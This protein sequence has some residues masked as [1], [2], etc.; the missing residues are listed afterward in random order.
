LI[1]QFQKSSQHLKHSPFETRLDLVSKFVGIIHVHRM[2]VED[3]AVVGDI[4]TQCAGCQGD[5]IRQHSDLVVCFGSQRYCHDTRAHVL[6]RGDDVV[7]DAQIRQEKL[8]D[9]EC[10]EADNPPAAPGIVPRAER[11]LGEE[12]DDESQEEPKQQV[13]LPEIPGC[14]CPD[15]C[16]E[17]IENEGVYGS[18]PNT[19]ST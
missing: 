17:K 2:D 3:A 10:G 15:K 18:P 13:R 12:D 8:P 19:L 7:R 4:E 5:Q 1:D 16:Q 6:G 11:A 9:K 14:R